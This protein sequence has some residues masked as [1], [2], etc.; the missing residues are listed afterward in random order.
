MGSN[1][2]PPRQQDH[3]EPHDLLLGKYELGRLLGRGTFA[4][5]YSARPLSDPSPSPSEP[6]S[7]VAIKVLDKPHLLSSGVAPMVLREVSAMRR[8]SSHPNILRLHEVMATKSKIYLVMEHARGGE[9]LSRLA[10]HGRLPEPAARR[11]FH[12]L[13]SALRFCHAHGITHRDVKP[14]NLLLDRHGNLKLSDFGLSALPDQ[15]RHDGLLHTACGTPAYTAPEVVR[16]RARGGYDGAKADAWSCGVFLFVLLAGSLPFDDSNLPL[17]YRKIHRRDYRFPPWFSSAAK[18][19]VSSLLD[20]NPETRISIDGVMELPWLMRRAYSVD[21]QLSLLTYLP[22]PPAPASAAADDDDNGPIVPPATSASDTDIASTMNAF[23]II[24]LSSG[25]DLSGMFDEGR[26][27]RER[28]FTSTASAERILERAEEI[29]TK[30][31]YNVTKRGKGEVVGRGKWG[32]VLSVEVSPVAS[33][34]LMVEVKVEGA[35]DGKDG[36]C[37]EDLRTELGDLVFDCHNNNNGT[38]IGGGES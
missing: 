22:P 7:T 20:P 24:S 3:Q 8:L 32:S 10:R 23:D 34:V 28:R 15:L 11:Y 27:A 35:G 37:W 17:M 2:K 9:L 12:Q 19:V 36:F 13:L 1:S 26:G 14:E 30:L 16:A 31:G 6:S 4:K 33:P 38:S 18:R 5:V 21:S 29:G 25:L